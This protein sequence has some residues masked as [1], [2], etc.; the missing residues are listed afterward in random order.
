MSQS[1]R[2]KEDLRWLK[3]AVPLMSADYWRSSHLL[4]RQA[5]VSQEFNHLDIFADEKLILPKAVG[6]YFEYL[7]NWT[8]SKSCKILEAQLV[9]QQKKQTLGELDSVYIG[10][11]G[12][13]V[14]REI[15]IKYY[16]STE[17]CGVHSTWVGPKQRDRLDLKLKRL[18]N[19]QLLLP[20]KAK[21]LCSWPS[22]L[23]YPDIHEVLLL[24]S[25][26]YRYGQYSRP[27]G[28][29]E[30]AEFGFWCE[31]SNWLEASQG[32]SWS[33]LPKPWWLSPCQYTFEPP[34]SSPDLMGLVEDTQQ[35][36]LVGSTLGR[37][38][39]V[40]KGWINMP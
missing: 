7:H 23:P 35:P 37:A 30:D 31:T 28:A 11:E 26:F 36:I 24:G 1:D 22:E 2:I 20:Q 5:S 14:H 15:A 10:A 18:L 38:F 39:V 29:H 25:F 32:Y 12:Q 6:R 3:L 13:I 40:P 33:I 34:C 17:D 21:K 8:L 16:L 4:V 19:H 27:Y 9:L